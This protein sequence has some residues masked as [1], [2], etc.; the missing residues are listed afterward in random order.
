MVFISVSDLSLAR[1]HC[2]VMILSFV[3]GFSYPALAFSSQPTSS[4]K[5]KK[6]TQRRHN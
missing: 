5:E 4:A 1:E 3:S 6:R 2:P